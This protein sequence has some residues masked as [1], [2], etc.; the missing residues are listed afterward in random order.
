MQRSKISYSTKLLIATIII[1]VV[2]SPLLMTI[3]TNRNVYSLFYLP[4]C[5]TNSGNRIDDDEFSD[6]KLNH[7]CWHKLEKQFRN[8]VDCLI[9]RT[10]RLAQIDVYDNY[11][12]M[13]NECFQSVN[14]N[15]STRSFIPLTSFAAGDEV[16]LA[17]VNDRLNEHRDGGCTVVTI[18]IGQSIWAEINIKKRLKWYTIRV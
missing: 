6:I 5:T 11:G 3:I 10:V 1:I 14:D 12:L 7:T 16:K 4:I 15:K 18:G 2:S 13:L 8:Y 17:I 9:K